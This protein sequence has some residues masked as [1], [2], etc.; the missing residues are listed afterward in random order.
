MTHLHTFRPLCSARRRFLSTSIAALLCAAPATRAINIILV[1]DD[2]G[3]N[4]SWD[5]NGTQLMAIAHAAEARWERLIPSAGT[6]TVDVSWSELE[7]TPTGAQLGLWKFDPFGNNNLYFNRD[8]DWFLDSTPNSD[9]EFSF[10]DPLEFASGFGSQLATTTPNS[11]W[12]TGANP[13]A[14]LEVGHNGDGISGQANDDVDLLSVIL[15]ELGHELG[16]AGDE[17]SGTYPIYSSHVLGITGLEAREL[18]LEG[19]NMGEEH[20]HLAPINALM[21]PNLPAGQRVLPSALDVLVAARDSNYT[22]VDLLRKFAGRSGDWADSTDWIGGRVPDADDTVFLVHGGTTTLGGARTADSLSIDDNTL[23][24]ATGDLAIDTVL[25]LGGTGT[26]RNHL[27]SEISAATLDARAYSDIELSGGRVIVGGGTLAENAK[28][29]GHGAFEVNGTLTVSGDIEAVGDLRLEG[30][31]ALLLDVATHPVLRAKDGNIGLGIGFAA[32]SYGD[33]LIYSGRALT[34][35]EDVTIPANVNVEMV[36]SSSGPAVINSLGSG[37]DVTIARLSVGGSGSSALGQINSSTLTLTDYAIVDGTLT[38]ASPLTT[39]RGGV[40]I[41]GDNGTL[42]QAGDISVQGGEAVHIGVNV[43]DWGNSTSA[44]TNSINIAP[45]ATLD[46]S[47]DSLGS[48]TN[49]FRG[50]IQV[51]SGVLEVGSVDPWTLVAPSGSTPGGT[52]SLIHSGTADPVVRGTAFTARHILAVSGGNAFIESDLTVASTGQVIV[53]GGAKLFL[54]GNTT[55]NGGSYTGLGTLVQRGDIK[56]TGDTTMAIETFDWGNS[57]ALDFNTLTVGSGATLTVNSPGTGNPDNQF[58]GLVRLEGGELIMNTDGPWTLP[59]SSPFQVPGSLELHNNGI[60]PRLGGMGVTVEA[61]LTVTGGAAHIDSD[62][63]FLSTAQI[64]IGA[65]ATLHINAGA[66]YRG[67]YTGAG[68]L[69]HNGSALLTSSTPLVIPHFIQDGSITVVAFGGEVVLETQTLLFAN[70]STTQLS[71]NLR[72][73]GNATIA[74]GAVF[75]GG[76]S[77]IVDP[78]GVLTVQA[79]FAHGIIN[80]GALLPGGTATLSGPISGPGTL[81]AQDAGTKTLAGSVANT[82]TGLTTISAGTLAL[83]KTGGNAVGG[84]ILVS[85]TGT[86]TL[87]Q[88]NQIVDTATIT[89]TSSSNV[90]FGNETFANAVV[91]PAGSA[92]FIARNGFNATGTIEIEGGIFSVAS[93]ATIVNV[94]GFELNDGILRI[95]ANTAPSTLNVGAG[96]IAAQGGTIQVGQGTGAFDAVL[97]LGGDFLA[98][99]DLSVT[100]GGFFGAQKREINLGNVTRTFDITNGTTIIEPDIRNGG[101]L[102][103]GAGRLVLDGAQE[104]GRLYVNAGTTDLNAPLVKGAITNAGGTLNLSEDNYGSSLFAEGG[105]TNIYADQTL[106]ELIIGDGAMVVLESGAPFASA[107]HVV[108]EPSVGALL[109]S[110]LAALGCVRR[111]W[112]GFATRRPVCRLSACARDGLQTRPT[113]GAAGIGCH[114]GRGCN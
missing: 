29:F 21:S 50:D 51:D 32:G 34:A 83:N 88:P 42:V 78:A 104:Y 76:N 91:D 57:L 1:Y 109:I 58:R 89:H 39:L 37:I 15:H 105:T 9:S 65:G 77:L 63:T 68:T 86:F 43:F 8:I 11:Q 19:S 30:T 79:N 90:D 24:D 5:P 74:P 112:D 69:Q 23:L 100:R 6:H 96:G 99:A 107:P 7:I 53:F 102:K 55:L 16:V 71:S 48:S 52:L 85:G 18:N 94:R 28:I 103:E 49:L 12:F 31:G 47:S 33:I 38:F 108:P 41:L 114:R 66:H 54:M 60:A 2:L 82:Y 36:G 70:T 46:I 40:G 26:L 95:A 81:T 84:S 64:D 62:A 73:R 101:I 98:T 87:L 80:Q 106:A 20:G 59:P 10:G 45:N 22:S 13:P 110:A 97:N 4:P 27:G 44:Q 3:E 56:V 17:F 67:T 92:Q 25:R 61:G 75:T 14:M 72:L 113:L 35:L 111:K 93:N